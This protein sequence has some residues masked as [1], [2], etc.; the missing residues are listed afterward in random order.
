MTTLSPLPKCNIIVVNNVLD[1]LETEVLSTQVWVP[2][3]LPLPKVITL[4]CSHVPLFVQPR[5]ILILMN[6]YDLSYFILALCFTL[7]LKST[8]L[9]VLPIPFYALEPDTQ[10]FQKKLFLP[11]LPLS[12]PLSKEVSLYTISTFFFL[13]ILFFFFHYSWISSCKFSQEM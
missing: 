5:D 4:T 3:S 2:W 13:Y 9:I 7:L 1:E 8:L 12:F 11:S 6:T 10:H